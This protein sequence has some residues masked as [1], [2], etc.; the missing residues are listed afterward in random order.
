MGTVDILFG[1]I[2]GIFILIGLWKGFF[3][4]VLG[5]AGIIGGIFLAII[6][7]G[8]LGQVLAGLAPGVPAVVWPFLSF[9]LIFVA[10]YLGSRLLAGLLSKL[11]E[12]IFLGW[13]NHLLGGL[14]GGLK[15]AAIISLLLLII[16]FF[17]MQG[18]LQSIRENSM[19][20]GPLQKFVPS[21]YNL[22]TG[23]NTSSYNFENRVT[24][25]L[26]DAK[27]KLSDEIIKYMFYGKQDSATINQ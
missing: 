5:F 26:R 27:V 1:V 3:R 22:F 16:G 15:G 14:V 20:Y 21:I 18:K 12:S 25:T 8:P 4:E 23:F 13:L 2:L 10:V 6:G 9:I 17:P 11:S 19:L 24:G 7:F